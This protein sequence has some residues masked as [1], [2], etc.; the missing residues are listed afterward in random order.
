MTRPKGI[1]DFLTVALMAL[2]RAVQRVVVQRLAIVVAVCAVV[3]LALLLPVRAI[4]SGTGGLP[5][6]SYP[7][8]GK[9]LTRYD[10]GTP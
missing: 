6:F 10:G 7:F 9:P 4:Q 5:A 2:H 8:S 1:T 3:G